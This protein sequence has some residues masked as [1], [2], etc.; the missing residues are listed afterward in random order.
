VSGWRAI[1]FDLDD[2][3]YPERDYV[4]RGFRA[5]AAWSDPNL[6]IP[7]DLPMSGDERP[8]NQVPSP[9]MMFSNDWGT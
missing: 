5:V 2:T 4:L 7:A 9:S 8:G 3:L 1:V 6:G